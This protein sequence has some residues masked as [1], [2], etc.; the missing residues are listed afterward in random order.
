[1]VALLTLRPDDT[2][3]APSALAWSTIDCSLRPAELATFAPGALEAEPCT[4]ADDLALEFGHGSHYLQDQPAH[5]SGAR[6]HLEALGARYEGDAGALE[7]LNVGEDVDARAAEAVELPDQDVR[8]SV[9]PGELE[10]T[11]QAWAIV[12]SSRPRLFY[13]VHQVE[14]SSGGRTPELVARER[15][16]L[17]HRRD[18]VVRHRG[19]PRRC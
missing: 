4:L 18:P 3:P 13:L 5:R 11:L 19:G 15:W 12:P 16:I 6:P 8:D 10:D 1:M 14:A 9:L 2:A 17:V 7:L